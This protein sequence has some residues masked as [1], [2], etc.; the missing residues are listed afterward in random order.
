MPSSLSV[1]NVKAALNERLYPSMTVWNRLEGR[2]RTVA[3]DQALRAEVRDPLWMLTKQ[4]QMGEFRGA[5]AG[6]PVFA[7]LMLATTELTKYRPNEQAAEPFPTDTP[8]EVKVERRRLTL[9]L[10]GHPIALD[11]RLTMGRYWLK[12]L[13]QL[14]NNYGSD[15]IKAYP[16]QRPDPT[17]ITQADRC[18]HLEAWQAFEATAGRAIDGG[19]LYEYLIASPAHHAYDNIATIAPGDYPALDTLAGRFLAWIPRAISMPPASS[20]DA[21]VPNRLEYQFA[22]SAPLPDGTEKVYVA[23][24]YYQGR[25]DWYSVDVDAGTASLGNIAGAPAPASSVSVRTMIPTP[26]SF[27]GMPNTRW[28]TFEDR[29]TNFG[30]IN[31]STTDLAKLLFMEFALVYSNDW[32]VIPYTLPV[33]SIATVNGMA[34]TNVFGDRLWIAAAGSG[35]DGAW[36]RWNLF[37]I[38]IQGGPAAAS[39]QSLLMLPTV[40]HIQEGEILEEVLLIRDE[41][42]NMVWGIEKTVCL[43]S[44]EPK[45]GVEVAR[46][47]RAYYEATAAGGGGGGPPPPAAPISYRLMTSVPEN[48]IP[49][50]PVHAAA[51]DN[52]EV[53]LQRASMP[54]IIGDHPTALPLPLRKVKPRTVLLREGLDANPATSYFIVEEEVPRAGARLTQRY[55]RTRWIDGSVHTWLRVRKETGRGEGSSGLAFD[56]LVPSPKAKGS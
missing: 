43:S 54:R 22:A 9:D 11:L 21:W 1:G 38:N 24:E 31:A 4:W 48:W 49:F 47:E 42:A 20:D 46:E 14:P 5:D 15:Y 26:V 19:S 40:P 53:Q 55:E 45:R 23:D 32:F 52:R 44:G 6:S 3:F 37:E 29:A 34:V 12:L 28:W 39:D 8:L 25:L 35:A 16:I 7:R 27:A 2:P 17:D 36:Q 50:L 30:D 33:G 10:S 56:T 13:S 41:A 18:A 51:G